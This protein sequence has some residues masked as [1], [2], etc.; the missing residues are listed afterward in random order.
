MISTVAG[1]G[2]TIRRSAPRGL[3]A[4]EFFV[5]SVT[6]L[7]ELPTGALI[8]ADSHQVIL[9]IGTDGVVR[10]WAGKWNSDNPVP[11]VY[12]VDRKAARFRG[13]NGLGRRSRGRGLRARAPAR[14]GTAWSASART[15]SSCG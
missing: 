10:P 2:S 8:L 1:G 13:L 7:A 3:P 5:S 11:S 6:G 14:T 15:G 12:D 9:E 4:D